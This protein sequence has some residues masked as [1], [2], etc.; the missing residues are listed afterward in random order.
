MHEAG[1]LVKFGRKVHRSRVP[2]QIQVPRSLARGGP[3]RWSHASRAFSESGNVMAYKSRS[4]K[5]P[6]DTRPSQLAIPPGWAIVW[7]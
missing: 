4:K 1:I 5:S 2:E 3:R 7:Q 6:L